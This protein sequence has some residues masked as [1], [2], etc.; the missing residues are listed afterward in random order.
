MLLLKIIF[1]SVVIPVSWFIIS[2]WCFG[3]VISPISY[4]VGL[5]RVVAGVLFSLFDD[6]ILLSICLPGS[7]IKYFC[8]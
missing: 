5:V 3:A 7:C 2:V 1:C 4:I 6:R 8:I